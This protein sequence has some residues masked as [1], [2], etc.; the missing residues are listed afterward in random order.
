MRR[1]DQLQ[2]RALGIGVRDDGFGGNFFAGREHDAA[3]DAVLHANFDDFR[4]AANLRSG[5]LR[6]CG[7]GLRDRA[8]AA[9]GEPGRACGM[10]VAGGANEQH[11]AAARRPRAQ[12]CS[13][14]SARGDGGAQQFGLEIF[15]H[16]IGDRHRSPAQQAVHISLAEF[17]DGA[18]GLEHAPQIAGAGIVDVGRSQG[19][20]FANDLAHLGERCLELRDTSPH[21]SARTSRF[22]A[23]LFRRRG[24][25]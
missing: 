16:Q 7:H 4:A 3:G 8:H 1:I 22:P 12:E 13:E 6:G 19:E 9:G 18:S 5:L 15:R 23:R 11:Q 25:E 24:R 2:Q 21:L 17:A 20:R 14:D 10:R